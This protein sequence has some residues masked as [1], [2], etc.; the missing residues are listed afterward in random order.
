MSSVHKPVLASE[1]IEWLNLRNGGVYVD[2]TL[3]GA[4]HTRLM[5]ETLAERGESAT[6]IA[7]DRDAGP[8]EQAPTEVAGIPIDA[9]HSS[10]S[11]TATVLQ[12]IGIDAVDG[13]L[14]DLGL[15]SDQLADDSR[16]FSFDASG[17]LDLRFDVSRGEP[18]WKLIQ[19]LSETHLANLIYEFG[20]EKLSRR[21]AR[22]IVEVRRNE[23]LRSASS[24][25]KV[26]RRAVNSATRQRGKKSERID[27]ATRTFQAL[28]IAVNE[29]L[30]LLGQALR[31]LPGLL[32]PH[33]RLLIISFHSLEDRMVKHSFREDDRLTVLTRKPIRPDDSEIASNRRSR[34]SRLRVAEKLP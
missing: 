24:V 34:S 30:K 26:I 32:N 15:S 33:G 17:D 2:G 4:G 29:E 21:I 23:E 7:L 5:A 16:G 31:S 9:V 14:L 20:E 1:V 12:R 11:E 8:V 18:A 28:R 13:I 6:L 10:Y 19:R 25:A 27:P 3:G 22:S